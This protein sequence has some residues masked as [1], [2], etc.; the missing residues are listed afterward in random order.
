MDRIRKKRIKRYIAWGCIAALVAF[1]AAMPLMAADNS[2]DDGPVATVKSG[3]VETGTITNI[4]NGGGT[5]AEDAAVD[6]TIPSGVKL[7]EFLVENG[8]T[9]S[10]GDALAAVDRVSVMTAIAEVQETLDYLDEEIESTD[11]ES[12]SVKITAQTAGKVKVV[13][14]KP[15]DNVQNV[16]LEHGALAV[17]SLDGRMALDVQTDADLNVG[18]SV[19]VKL[20]EDE[21][22]TGHVESTLGD[23]VIIT[24][25]DNGYEVGAAARVSSDGDYLGYG[26]LYIHNPWNAT[27]FY[28]TVSA[29]KVAENDDVSAGETLITLENTDHATQYEILVGQRQEYEEVMQEL[30]KMYQAE[31]VTAPCDGIV[32]GVDEDSAYLLSGSN[33]GWTIELLANAPGEDPDAGYTNYL[34][35]VEAN[36]NGN[37]LLKVNPNPV[38][39]DDYKNI[40][41]DVDV[42]AMT[43]TG[44]LSA[45]YVY[46]LDSGGEWVQTTATRGSV[47][48]V[49]EAFGVYVTN[50]DLD[51]DPEEPSQPSGGENSD[52]SQPTEGSETTEP[53]QPPEGGSTTP[54]QPS[55]G[56]GEGN[57][58]S[59]GTQMPSGGNMSGF[60]GGYSGGIISEPTFEPYDLTESTILTVTPQDT[61]TLDVTIDE[62]DI[63][64]LTI[65]QAADITVSALMGKAVSGT[66]TGIDS[67]ENAGGNSKFAVT[68]TLNRGE[69]M[70]AGMSACAAME[71]NTVENALMIPVGALVDD[72]TQTFVYT[73][74]DAKTDTLGDPV[75]VTLGV[76]DG[77]NVQILSGLDAGAAY[78]YSYYDAQETP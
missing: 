70:L 3:T 59:G 20:E 5:L 26:K 73:S 17:L 22:V 43:E 53:S 35:V 42:S 71:L 34:A 27:A 33:D 51:S 48:V 8:D 67:A 32:S 2:E 61:M 30:F 39:I 64:K 11:Q 55:A 16:I 44:Y 12:G 47:L 1:L 46:A 18:E 19:L 72:G 60:G 21:E 28:G 74:Y 25:P 31:A 15:G 63:G 58:A 9:V 23:T 54:T 49:T 68:I 40:S 56:K 78:Y 10:Q 24:I 76:S 77:E 41:V 45:S 29:V 57:L 4:L 38:A 36:D 65:G 50:V 66:V 6:I 62:L 7:T 14:A 13:Y 37:L 69:D 75:A 52:P